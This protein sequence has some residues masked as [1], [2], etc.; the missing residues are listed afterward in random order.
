MVYFY[1]HFL[2]TDD[3]ILKLYTILCQ[4][5]KCTLFVWST[6]AHMTCVNW[7]ELSVSLERRLSTS[8][9]MQTE[10]SKRSEYNLLPGVQLPLVTLLVGEK[11]CRVM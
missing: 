3:V 4:K 8:W 7:N 5:A 9:W 6:V 1:Q 2:N 10:V 11:L